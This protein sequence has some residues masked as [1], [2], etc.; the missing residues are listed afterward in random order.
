MQVY[1]GIWTCNKLIGN[2]KVISFIW[3]GWRRLY[4]LYWLF[5]YQIPLHVLS[6]LQDESS[7]H[8][9]GKKQKSNTLYSFLAPL[10][11]ASAPSQ[12]WGNENGSN[13]FLCISV[14]FGIFLG[15]KLT[16]VSCEPGVQPHHVRH[17]WSQLFRPRL[18]S[19]DKTSIS[20][21]NDHRTW[22]KNVSYGKL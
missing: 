22:D 6:G 15:E 20:S 21:T 7:K 8:Q 18:Q 16:Q 2:I 4:K 13:D 9:N 3:S 12:G 17:S 10:N 19:G 1:R 11:S 5:S 14:P